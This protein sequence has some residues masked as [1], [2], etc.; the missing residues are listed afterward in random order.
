MIDNFFHVL[1]IFHESL[2][3]HLCFYQSLFIISIIFSA[4][5]IPVFF[6]VHITFVVCTLFVEF[7]TIQTDNC[8]IIPI[9]DVFR[10][11]STKSLQWRLLWPVFTPPSIYE[12]VQI[13]L[14]AFFAPCSPVCCM[15]YVLSAVSTI[16]LFPPT[17][18]FSPFVLN[19]APIFC[20]A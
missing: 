10:T 1:F 6:V 19:D 17:M 5:C 18:A 8:Y 2:P 16:T 14:P 12:C 13:W 4:R 11:L 15:C 20:L 7:S 9:T 3:V